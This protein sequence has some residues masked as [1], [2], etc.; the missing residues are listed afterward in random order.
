MPIKRRKP[1]T[2]IDTYRDF[3]AHHWNIQPKDGVDFRASTRHGIKVLVNLLE[4]M[5]N[6]NFKDI[7]H[8]P[9]HAEAKKLAVE[10]LKLEGSYQSL[11]VKG[12]WVWV[13]PQGHVDFPLPG[14][15]HDG[16]GKVYG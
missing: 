12:S 8:C 4:P 9:D 11:E 2:V 15:D 1:A 16:R 5:R 6:Q 13:L 3:R 10:L 14:Q 7:W